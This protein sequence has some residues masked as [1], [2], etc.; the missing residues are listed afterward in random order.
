MMTGNTTQLGIDLSNYLRN[1]SLDNRSKLEH[2]LSIV[3]GF[4]IGAF[5]GA[6]LY[7]Y[8]DFWSVAFFILPVLYL[9][10]LASQD[11]FIMP[12]T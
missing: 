4:V 8:L 6:L 11:R 9:S 5:L 7:V 12:E 10:F 2:S 3:L 1:R